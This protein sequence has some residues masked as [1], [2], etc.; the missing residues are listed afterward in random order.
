MLDW[1][2]FNNASLF[3]NSVIIEK[4]KL[5]FPSENK[6]YDRKESSTTIYYRIRSKLTVSY[7]FL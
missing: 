3:Q 7:F 1:A 6:L 5:T 2:Y 4:T